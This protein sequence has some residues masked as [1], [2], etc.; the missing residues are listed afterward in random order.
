MLSDISTSILQNWTARGH[1]VDWFIYKYDVNVQTSA[2]YSEFQA[3]VLEP[4]QVDRAG[5]ATN[6]SVFSIMNQLRD[7]WGTIYVSQSINWHIW[8]NSRSTEPSNRQATLIAQLPPIEIIHLF[9]HSP[10]DSEVL[11]SSLRE[12]NNTSLAILQQI[13]EIEQDFS[14]RM[15]AVRSNI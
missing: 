8:A 5:A 6:D 3:S 9:R 11:L 7:R 10:T 14:T 15:N 1:A 12:D 13:E 4:A 2:K